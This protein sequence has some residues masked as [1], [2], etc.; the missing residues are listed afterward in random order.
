MHLDGDEAIR[1]ID[2]FDSRF[3]NE[4]GELFGQRIFVACTHI[5][6]I[7]LGRLHLLFSCSDGFF[8]RNIQRI[9]YRRTNAQYPRAI[10]AGNA[11]VFNEKRV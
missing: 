10:G 4:P 11:C 2:G 7:N 6:K 9:P 3:F 8:C 1:K 5:R